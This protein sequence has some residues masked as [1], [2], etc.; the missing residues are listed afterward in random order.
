MS[1]EDPEVVDAVQPSSLKPHSRN[2]SE[3]LVFEW[4]VLQHAYAL[5]LLQSV[6]MRETSPSS[7]SAGEHRAEAKMATPGANSEIPREALSP[8]DYEKLV[9]RAI[10]QGGEELAELRGKARDAG[11]VRGK[12]RIRTFISKRSKCF[13]AGV[14]YYFRLS[15]PSRHRTVGEATFCRLVFPLEEGSKELS[16]MSITNSLPGS[17]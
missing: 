15:C 5:A 4:F 2:Q 1:F 14:Y 7:E 10:G 12:R 3:R 16:T 13:S 11:V 6:E 17:K 8:V 9:E